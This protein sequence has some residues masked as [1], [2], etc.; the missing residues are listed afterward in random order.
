M[1]L[2]PS[3]SYATAQTEWPSAV[4][5]KPEIRRLLAHFYY[6]LDIPDPSIG[7]RFADEVFTPDGVMFGMGPG[8]H[9]EGQYE[10][11]CALP[12]ARSA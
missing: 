7:H 11:T 12:L 4:F 6:L 3:S 10:Y 9:G 2:P 5:V 8:F 1:S